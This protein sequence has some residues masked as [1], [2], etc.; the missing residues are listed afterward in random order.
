MVYHCYCSI[1]ISWSK[2]NQ[3]HRSSCSLLPGHV[4]HRPCRWQTVLSSPSV[5]LIYPAPRL[6]AIPPDLAKTRFIKKVM[7]LATVARSL[8]DY[9]HQSLSSK[10][11]WT[12]RGWSR[13][14]A[15]GGRQTHQHL[16]TKRSSERG[17]RIMRGGVAVASMRTQT[18]HKNGSPL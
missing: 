16:K 5:H 10:P 17:V 3:N 13:C 1:V 9:E 14:V 6:E 18:T 15:F 2:A 7:L 11:R 4:Q 12:S 8:H